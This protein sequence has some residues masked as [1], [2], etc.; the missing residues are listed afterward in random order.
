MHAG[1]EYDLFIGRIRIRDKQF[2]SGCIRSDQLSYNPRNKLLLSR[3]TQ[4][5]YLCP[6]NILFGFEGLL[7]LVTLI[8]NSSAPKNRT[9]FDYEVFS[10]EK[11]FKKII[12]K[13]ANYIF[14]SSL[15]PH[16]A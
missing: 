11:A 9:L 6:R 14:L 5:G 8:Q 1:L 7:F 2:M 4:M 3:M 10:L 12:H 13:R 15:Q 16:K